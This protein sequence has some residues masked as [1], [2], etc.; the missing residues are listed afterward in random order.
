MATPQLEK[1]FDFSMAAE[2]FTLLMAASLGVVG[3]LGVKQ[4]DMIKS[5]KDGSNDSQKTYAN[6]GYNLANGTQYFG[7]ISFV[8]LFGLMTYHIGKGKDSI[9]SKG[10]YAA[11]LIQAIVAFAGFGVL[12]ANLGYD[13][14]VH[15]SVAEWQPAGPPQMIAS[16]SSPAVQRAKALAHARAK[17]MGVKVGENDPEAERTANSY[18]DAYVA[19]L[20]LSIILFIVYFVYF[21]MYTKTGKQL[22][23]LTGGYKGCGMSGGYSN[24]G[25]VSE[26]F[27][28]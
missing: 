23:G 28:Y 1:L 7:W 13:I 19:L 22:R 25:A 6:N 5:Y 10:P 20:V 21:I 12:W 15:K 18:Y 17:A 4:Y 2:T 9:Y 14:N 27:S 24:H 16:R 8:L 3:T 11:S 26:F